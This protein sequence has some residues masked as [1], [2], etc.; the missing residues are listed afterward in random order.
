MFL[1]VGMMASVS[2]SGVTFKPKNTDTK[3]FIHTSVSSNTVGY[4]HNPVGFIHN[5][6]K[7]NDA[8]LIVEWTPK[9]AKS[10]YVKM[11]FG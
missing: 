8:K 1:L 11:F 4:I 5:P 7:S 9:P 6:V 3:G 10:N 2:A